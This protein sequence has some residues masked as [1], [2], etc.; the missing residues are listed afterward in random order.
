[1][2]VLILEQIALFFNAL[3]LG[4]LICVLYLITKT[5]LEDIFGLKSVAWWIFWSAMCILVLAFFMKNQNFYLRGYI[6]FGAVLGFFAG[7]RVFEKPLRILLGKLLRPVYKGAQK[8]A[9]FS[10]KQTRRL[11]R[12]AKEKTKGVRQR[13]NRLKGLC[14]EKKMRYNHRIRLRRKQKQEARGERTKTNTLACKA[15]KPRAK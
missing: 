14:K 7:K 1:M 13:L 5:A 10:R 3:Y 9:A 6:V 4:V 2:R 12:F 11:G 8:T 15:K